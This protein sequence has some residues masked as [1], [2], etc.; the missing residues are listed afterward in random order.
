MVEWR[1]PAARNVRAAQ[2]PKLATRA[3]VS[4]SSTGV[5]VS[6]WR[7]ERSNPAVMA[8][9]PQRAGKIPQLAL[10]Y[11]PEVVWN[12]DSANLGL[13]AGGRIQ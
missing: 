8:A 5:G 1:Q 12:E 10:M 7:L 13:A 11:V 2:V 6:N 9:F 4:G 3:S